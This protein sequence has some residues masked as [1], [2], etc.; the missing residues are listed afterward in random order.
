VRN[1]IFF[2]ALLYVDSL[3]AQST[4]FLANLDTT[5]VPENIYL[6]DYN[7]ESYYSSGVGDVEIKYG[8]LESD[9]LNAAV[10]YALN[11][12]RERKRKTSLTYNIH[13]DY[14]AYNC[15]HYFS[16][17]KFKPSKKNDLLYEKNLYLAARSEKMSC[18]LF[19]AH[20]SIIP[21]MNIEPKRKMHRLRG[22]TRS[23]FGL[24]YRATSE[25]EKDEEKEPEDIVEA[26]TYNEFANKVVKALYKGKR[27]SR[28]S[29]KSYETMACYVYIDPRS[30]NRNKPPYA[31]VIQIIGAKRLTLEK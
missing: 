27:R 8:E 3:T 31:K 2:I 5:Y 26:L 25:P 17:S 6:T 18:H 4:R 19:S 21:I 16:K 10:F 1:L 24:Y 7:L 11:K 22:D 29:S 9:L 14:L 15:V 23:P 12:E 20:T 30:M 13:L 28:L